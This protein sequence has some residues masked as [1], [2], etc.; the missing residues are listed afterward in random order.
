MKTFIKFVFFTVLFLALIVVVM[1]N[2]LGRP[3]DAQRTGLEQSVTKLTGW[4]TH[5]GSLKDF[6]LAPGIIIVAEEIGS[7]PRMGVRDSDLMTIQQIDVHIPWGAYLAQRGEF[8]KLD[9]SGLNVPA[10]YA[11]VP[12]SVDEARKKENLYIVKGKIGER[13]AELHVPLLQKGAGFAF[14]GDKASGLSVSNGEMVADL[15]FYPVSPQLAVWVLSS[16][17]GN[18]DILP[19]GK[20]ND[21]AP[22]SVLLKTAGK[23]KKDYL[24]TR[25]RAAAGDLWPWHLDIAAQDNAAARAEART[26]LDAS[27]LKLP[28]GCVLE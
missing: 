22:C 12:L 10:R 16:F 4:H 8:R 20:F 27:G 2:V 21:G 14:D 5:I 17:K 6:A 3:G 13:P 9:I 24:L 15:Y 25:E 7:A 11:G 18:T 23:E 28:S 1:L 19:I 26:L